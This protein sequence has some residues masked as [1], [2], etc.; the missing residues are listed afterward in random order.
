MY[1]ATDNEIYNEAL[2]N[3]K[4]G[5]IYKSKAGEEGCY[6]ISNVVWVKN[7]QKLRHS[8]NNY[9]SQE[10]DSILRQ[11]LYQELKNKT[12]ENENS[13]VKLV[14]TVQFEIEDESIKSFTLCERCFVTFN[15][16]K[17]KNKLSF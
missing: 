8:R 13:K 4:C 12:F 2:R 15:Q 9:T 6:A 16:H 7:M 14:F 1:E 10:M 17:S 5:C 11:S 3:C